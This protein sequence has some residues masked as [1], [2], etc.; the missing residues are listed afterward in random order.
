MRCL[1]IALIQCFPVS[2]NIIEKCNINNHFLKK[3]SFF[4]VAP[5][6]SKRIQSCTMQML[7]SFYRKEFF[8]IEFLS[9]S[10]QL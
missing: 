7:Q 10:S 6:H 3:K 8:N 9:R 5:V 4:F 2:F 1:I